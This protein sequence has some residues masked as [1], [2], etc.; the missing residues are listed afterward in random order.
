MRSLKDF[1]RACSYTEGRIQNFDY[2]WGDYPL[3]G[4]QIKQKGDNSMMTFTGHYVLDTLVRCS[5]S[6]PFTTGERYISTS[7]ACGRIFIFDTITG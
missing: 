4:K 5:W 1:T 7:S 6:P 2:R 3:R